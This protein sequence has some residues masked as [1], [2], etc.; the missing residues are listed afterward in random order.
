MGIPHR[1]LLIIVEK[2]QRV[3]SD[4][5]HREHQWP[6]DLVKLCGCGNVEETEAE[7]FGE[8]HCCHQSISAAQKNQR[9]EKLPRSLAPAHWGS[10]L[11]NDFSP[12]NM[13]GDNLPPSTEEMGHPLGNGLMTSQQVFEPL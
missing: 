11:K 9:A 6:T 5:E 2:R 13:N 8:T 12:Q 4:I 10:S 3:V 7:L 1:G